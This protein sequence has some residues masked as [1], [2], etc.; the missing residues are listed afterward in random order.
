MSKRYH[1]TLAEPSLLTASAGSNPSTCSGYDGTVTVTANGGGTPPYQYSIDNG[2]TYQA[3]N[4]FTGVANG[5]YNIIV[6][7][8]NQCTANAPV[9]VNRIDNM[10][11][12]ITPRD[13]TICF[14]QS[15]TFQPQT[16]PETTI[17]VWTSPNAAITTIDDDS[18]KNATVTPVDTA[19]YILHAQLGVCERW[20]STDVYV[21][22]KPIANAGPD[23]GICYG[24]RT[25][26]LTGSATNLSGGVDYSW[27]PADSLQTPLSP[28]TNALVDATTTFTLTVTDTYGC[29]FIV[30]DQVTIFVQPP[31]PAFAGNDT[32]AMMGAPHQ[33]QGSGGTQYLW[34]P[35]G[36]FNGTINNI[37][38]PHALV[39]F[40]SNPQ[41]VRF[42]LEVRDQFGCL[43]RD[44]VFIQVYEG[45]TYYMPNAFSPNGD[46][47]NDIFR[48]VPV[49]IANTQ[50]F[51]IFNRFGEMVFET[52]KWLKG[53]DG[54]YKGQKQ[55][56]G[57]YIWVIKGEDKYGH[58][59]EMKG[60]VLIIQ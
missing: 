40:Y 31:V 12:A 33:M 26:V 41:G 38:D 3:S 60:T 9:V 29:N 36:A 46:G 56:M 20:D 35:T 48:P 8:A 27:T 15:V 19:R 47:L 39:T 57:V 49:G 7:D 37:F 53:W 28:V 51:R 50:W 1:R 6:R 2:V 16:N 54:K 18:I 4:I 42:A 45:P 14:G 44:S 25:T 17:F 21:L 52:N 43:G 24:S 10:V 34:T 30:T 22:H 55:P 5:S 23:A 13:T 32:I 58:A 59:V 11:L